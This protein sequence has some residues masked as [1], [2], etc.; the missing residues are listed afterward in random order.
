MSWPSYN[1]DK[2]LIAILERDSATLVEIK[3][4][5]IE[6]K[7]DSDLLG[8]AANQ[9]GDNDRTVLWYLV[10]LNPTIALVKR[11]L[12][13]APDTIKLRC[14]TDSPLPLHAAIEAQASYGVIKLL[15]NA[16][17]E[18][19]R[20][21]DAFL[22]LP[23]HL[24]LKSKNNF[25]IIKILLEVYPEG[26]KVEDNI[27]SLPL[28]YAVWSSFDVVKLLLD[29]Y[30]EGVKVRGKEGNLPLHNAARYYNASYDVVKLLLDA[31]PKGVKVR[32]KKGNLPLHNSDAY[33][34]VKLLLDAYPEGVEVRDKDGNLPLHNA[35]RYS[36][37]YDV[38][39]LLLDAYPEGV[40][41]RDKDG[42]LPLHNSV[43][44]DVVKL[45][46]DAYP[47]GVEV[48]DK[49][50]NLPLH[51]AARYSYAY[52]V[53]KLL[54]DAY[55]EGVEVRDKDGNLPLRMAIWSDANFNVIKLLIDAY[56]EGARV[57]WNPPNRVH[58]KASHLRG[59]LP[60]HLACM[61][62]MDD[63]KFIDTNISLKLLEVYPEGA[64]VQ[65]KHKNLPLHYAVKA[66]AIKTSLKLLKLYP[67]GVKVQGCWGKLPLH[68]AV[69]DAVL[70]GVSEINFNL[71]DSLLRVYPESIHVRCD[72]YMSP[73]DILVSVGKEEGYLYLLRAMKA[74][75]SKNCLKLFL[76]AF[77]E[78]CLKQDNKGMIPLHH[79]C[80]SR[81][82]NR[83]EYIHAFLD[84]HGGETSFPHSF[85]KQFRVQDNR[86]R[87]PFQVL[88]DNG[89][90]LL[91]ELVATSLHLS[92]TAVRLL[93]DMMP[94][95]IITPNKCGMLP[96]HY[97]CLNPAISVELLMLFIRFSPD[98]LAPIQPR[99]NVLREERSKKR[100]RL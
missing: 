27:G 86:G 88:P 4:W 18:A 14:S 40:E 3:Q 43:A 31:Y 47:E 48:R 22:K 8:R 9:R 11:I 19:A 24:A 73:L 5:L 96:F 46:L 51:N 97:A 23:L 28:H 53:V 16:Y 75:V 32:D 79:A 34:V 61:Y 59:T 71:L 89:L 6:H 76:L 41:V 60:L 56:P 52:D 54:L 84:I 90:F 94:N 58:P 83:H 55:P 81:L 2:G 98:A 42:N 49:D 99:F 74:G 87:T 25:S 37:A 15:L 69:E 26:V 67:E 91:H 72:D 77:P 12:Q 33:D 80:A 66:Q 95:S 7:G 65:D 35:A 1:E 36:Y 78:S 20:V 13:L 68:Y 44:Y 30:P 17:P 57:S 45:L 62:P 92:E 10:G 29:T 100:R 50:G 38:V 64:Q 70:A 63:E 93:V 21:Q 82:P 39:K 85:D